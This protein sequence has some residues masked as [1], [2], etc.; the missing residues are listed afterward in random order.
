MQ[1]FGTACSSTMRLALQQVYAVTGCDMAYDT[2]VC[3]LTKRLYCYVLSRIPS[4][5][6]IVRG[7]KKAL[8]RPVSFS[9]HSTFTCAATIFF[10]F[11]PLSSS[12]SMVLQ[13][14]L[15]SPKD[16]LMYRCT[17]VMYGITMPCGACGPELLQFCWSIEGHTL[18]EI[19]LV[20][21]WMKN[22]QTIA[23]LS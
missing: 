23:F 7:K 12:F 11:P 1:P 9:N 18:Y 14:S 22:G 20:G 3:T 13:T 10:F 2:C 21:L 19:R 6:C 5:A 8:T 16:S 4:R 15:L 17:T